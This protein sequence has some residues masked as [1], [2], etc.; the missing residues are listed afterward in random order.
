LIVVDA[1]VLV[2][3]LLQSTDADALMARMFDSGEPLAAPHLIDVEVAQVLRRYWRSGQLP[4]RR[5]S[6]GILDLASFPLERFGHEP[7]LERMWALRNNVTAYDASY[8]S[9]AEA[10]D[11]VLITRDA[12]LA[13]VP[14]VR[15]TVEVL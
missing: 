5:A 4:A 6:E 3:V 13:R 11:A 2:D 1:S 12:R 8:I 15:A 7:L 14:G 9:L 10:L